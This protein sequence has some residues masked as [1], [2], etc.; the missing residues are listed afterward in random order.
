MPKI[1]FTPNTILQFVF[2]LLDTFGVIVSLI[3]FGEKS[4][5]AILNSFVIIFFCVIDAWVLLADFPFISQIVFIESYIGRG[6]LY[7]IIG[8]IFSSHRGLRLASWIIFWIAGIFSIVIHFLNF[9]PFA[10]I[11]GQRGPSRENYEYPNNGNNYQNDNLT[12]DKGD[13]YHPLN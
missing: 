8:C 3:L 12:N 11:F 7:I 13:A 6:I 10:P 4:A 9:P 2:I 5:H 1:N